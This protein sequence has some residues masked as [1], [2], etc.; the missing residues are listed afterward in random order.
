MSLA[1]KYIYGDKRRLHIVHT[2]FGWGVQTFSIAIQQ[3]N[4]SIITTD[5]L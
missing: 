4:A 5:K 1:F 3:S 2:K